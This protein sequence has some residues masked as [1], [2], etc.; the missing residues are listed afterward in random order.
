[1]EFEIVGLDGMIDKFGKAEQTIPQKISDMAKKLGASLQGRVKRKTPVGKYKNHTGGQ[2][3]RSWHVKKIDDYSVRVYND[4]EY[5]G[6]VEYGHRTR[7]GSKFVE[8]R[9]MLARSLEELMDGREEMEFFE[10]IIENIW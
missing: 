2:L 5:A 6:Y 9:F 4:T 10:S 3:R 7:N 8:G 1:M